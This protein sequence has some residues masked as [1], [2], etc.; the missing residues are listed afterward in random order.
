M[1]VFSPASLAGSPQTIADFFAT[2][3]GSPGAIISV[4]DGIRT[5]SVASGFSDIEDNT[6]LDHAQSFKIGSQTKMMTALTVLELAREGRIDLDRPLAD[7]LETELIAG[8]A[9]AET[10]T[11]RQALQ[12]KT[13]I[14]NYT[15]A[16]SPDGKTLLNIVLQN[17]D[18]IFGEDEIIG[19]LQ[20]LPATAAV[21]QRYEYSNTN[22]FYLSKVI[23]AVTGQDLGLVF[24]KRIFEP[25]GMT[26]TYLNDF[27]DNPN[28]V[29]NYLLFD[30]RMV[31]TSGAL[32]DAYGEGGVVST[33]A[34]MTT[35]LNALLVEKTLTSGT[36]LS[37]MTDFQNGEVDARGFG[38]NYGLGTFDYDDLGTFVGFA[39]SIFGTDS[40]TYLHLESGRI[41]STMVNLG[42]GDASG[43]G[44]MI[45]IAAALA[46]DDMWQKDLQGGSINIQDI[47]AADL[48]IVTL[49]GV[50]SLESGGVQFRLGDHIRA[51][52]SD[53]F[54]FKDDSILYLGT[55]HDDVLLARKSAAG[56]NQLR[57][58][59]GQDRLGGASGDDHLTG[60]AGVDALSGRGGN[61]HLAG[62]R[63]SDLLKGQ[64]GDD[65]LVGGLGTDRLFGGSGADHL[66]GG[67][68]NDKLTGGG[69]ADTFVFRHGARDASVD[70]DILTDFQIGVDS[71]ALI[72]R[73]IARYS[74]DETGITL[75]LNGEADTIF[76]KDLHDP[77]DLTFL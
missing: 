55:N 8:V 20:G 46:E 49:D 75:V 24:D 12:M 36:V 18:D 4:S 56:D 42:N 68:G 25:L 52:D 59:A 44:A 72:G 53:D 47:S 34:D 10:A 43:T 6:A 31:D 60:G 38:F 66:S 33:A 69:G 76:L 54:V 35:F 22:Y 40:A 62:G 51:F 45:S 77:S 1:P 26:D 21:G 61:D 70:H 67:A 57:G 71:I 17:P 39:G 32:I 58:F 5:A 29:S 50:S 11:V 14:Q 3:A 63:G 41:I 2:S 16:Q 28:L 37:T 15:A 27:R 19:L 30:G 9:N 23:E 74:T 48:R 64:R 13:G 7:Y 73:T 65:R